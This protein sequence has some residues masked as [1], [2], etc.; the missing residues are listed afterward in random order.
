MCDLADLFFQTIE[1]NAILLF[2]CLIYAIIHTFS[3]FDITYTHRLHLSICD[4]INDTQMYMYKSMTVAYCLSQ[5]IP[6]YNFSG[7]MF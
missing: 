5:N 7:G 3:I 2:K 1:S 6:W 4:G